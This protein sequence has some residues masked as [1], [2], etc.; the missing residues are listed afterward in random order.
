MASKGIL[1][2]I[3]ALTVIIVAIAV[4]SSYHVSPSSQ[5]PSS[6]APGQTTTTTTSSY[7]QQTPVF[8]TDPP[9]VPAGT[10]A[11]I[12][13]YSSL[14]VHT[15]GTSGSGWVSASGS[16]T[17]NLLNLVNTSELIGTANIT[18]NSTI[19][20]ISFNVTSAKI[21]INGTTSNV[22]L[23]NPKV[24]AHIVGRTKVNA[25]S[26]LLLDLSPTIATI[27]TANSTIFVMVPSVRAV[28][29]GS[30][31]THASSS[32]G[33]REPLNASDRKEL[34]DVRPNISIVSSSM[35]ITGNLTSVSVT[36][37]DNSNSSVTLRH[38]TIF[39]NYSVTVQVPASGLNAT[40]NTTVHIEDNGS[41]SESG[42]A[43]NLTGSVTG[44]SNAGDY[45][46]AGSGN[47]S[48]FGL[49]MFSEAEGIDVQHLHV[50]NFLINQNSTLS[51][52]SLNTEAE[53]QASGYNLTAGSTATFTFS[54]RLSFG[55]GRITIIPT[56]GSQYRL[57]VTGE[58][59]ANASANVTAK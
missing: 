19:N 49:D 54:G 16:G 58:V 29:V 12:I 55:K 46:H 39:G 27:Y 24:T 14:A 15:E 34:E 44:D 1:V 56:S 37:K 45:G 35:S 30:Q 50:F 21:T 7:S 8:L 42:V 20:M 33:A 10:T 22:T 31:S 52:P 17:I 53:G 38:V 13:T 51:L 28:V 9:V 4:L 40:E 6:G 41:V 25:S 43:L 5:G 26:G 47:Q 18:A 11:L 57:L 36:V 3:A 32:I 48:S 59:D 23:P 2:G